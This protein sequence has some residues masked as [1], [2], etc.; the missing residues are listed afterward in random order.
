[1]KQLAFS[2]YDLYIKQRINTVK[3]KEILLEFSGTNSRLL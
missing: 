3:I 2:K 1:M